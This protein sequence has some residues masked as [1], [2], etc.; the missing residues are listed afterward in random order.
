MLAFMRPLESHTETLDPVLFNWI[1]N[2]INFDMQGDFDCQQSLTIVFIY[3][4]LKVIYNQMQESLHK[5][6]LH[7]WQNIPRL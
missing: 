7:Y 4:D 6:F 2:G 1:L 5:G 3:Q